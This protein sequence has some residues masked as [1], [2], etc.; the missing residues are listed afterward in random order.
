MKRENATRFVLAACLWCSALAAHAV[1]PLGSAGVVSPQMA[2]EKMASARV[3][4]I[5][6]QGQVSNADVRFY[7]Q[8]FA[9][10]WRITE[11]EMWD[12][13]YFDMEVPAHITI[14]EDLTGEFQ[15]GLVQGDA[16]I[17]V[18]IRSSKLHGNRHSRWNRPGDLL[19]LCPTWSPGCCCRCRRG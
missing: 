15:F 9:G 2:A 3:P 17:V 14:R 4:F 8:T 6:N 10:T 12:A 5:R 1:A 13:E 18:V 11:M 16:M 19:G 7:A